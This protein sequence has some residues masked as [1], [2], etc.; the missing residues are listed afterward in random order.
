MIPI[1]VALALIKARARL[2]PPRELPLA[3]A[4][5]CVLAEDI[6]A[7]RDS[8]PYPKALMDGYA[9]AAADMASGEAELA[10]LEEV[11][12]GAVPT[13][14]VTAG[15]CTRIMTGAPLP[16]GAEAVVQVEHTE[17][18]SDG[19]R[20]RLNS[21]GI[22]PGVN[23]MAQG[24]S[25]RQGEVLLPK[26]GVISPAQV[27]LMAEV[28]R[29]A[30]LAVPRPRV[31]VLATGN[32]LVPPGDVPG[33]GQIRNSNGPL[34]AA[35][36]R[37]AGG[38]PV[39]LGIARD[40]PE[41]LAAKIA[42]GLSCDLLILSGGVSAG[43]LDLVPAALAA[44]GVSEVFHKVDLK[45]GKPLWFGE[46]EPKL[47]FGLPGN[48]VSTLVCFELFARPAIAA[49]AGRNEWNRTQPA[50]LAAPHKLK[51]NRPTF[52]PGKLV[53]PERVEA[54]PW[55]GSADLATLARADCLIAFP[56]GESEYAAGDPIAI[57][58]L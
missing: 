48:P 7:D 33:P 58:P 12:A 2:L 13:H 5:G 34:T 50:T 26:G 47:I 51:G 42:E 30:V 6:A 54:L 49:L 23:V 27:G 36:V 38:E 41:D 29:A 57:V 19:A 44:A 25:F 16:R 8:P 1:D 55:R 28:G 22:A 10:V 46:R 14:E 20:V 56:T 43:V 11:T 15:N 9:V 37:R 52:W 35:L 4:A 24:E 17:L 18:S 31:A 40:E 32:E 53:G 3:E 45:P 39:D 21:P